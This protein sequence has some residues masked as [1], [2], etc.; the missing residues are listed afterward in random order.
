MTETEVKNLLRFLAMEYSSF[1][2]IDDKVKYWYNELQQYDTRDVKSRL[3]E[4]MA[5]EKYALVPPVLEVIISGLTKKQNK[6][7]FKKMV[8]FC[9]F[10]N[11]AFNVRYELDKH[12]D[13]CRS[14]KYILRQYENYN[15]GEIDKKTLYNMTDEEFD[16]RYN[17]L[18][19][20]IKNK[21]T[22]E[23]EKRLIEFIFN[24]PSWEKAK[25]FLGN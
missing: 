16:E 8:Y 19:Q 15:L 10:C 5:N 24:P 21:T 13:R 9:K 14:I 4:L 12:E 6:V 20:V 25:Q 18:L 17:K 23:G 11:R 1:N 3:K 2:V 22:D 7:N